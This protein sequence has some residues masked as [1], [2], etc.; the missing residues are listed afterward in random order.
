MQLSIHYY[1]LSLSEQ[2]TKLYE[3]FRDKLIDIQNTNFPLE[4]SIDAAN[5]ASENTQLR[6]LFSQT[7]QHFA[8]Y[9]QQDPL[10]LVVVGEKNNLAIF[11]ALTTHRDAI[12]GTVKGNYTVTSSHDLGK[13]VWPVVKE[14][15]AGATKNAMR[16]LTTAAK[17]K[18]VVSGIGAVGQSAE[19]E[20][21]ST[22][23]VEEDYHVKGSI[24]K[25]DHSLIFSKHV[26]IWEVIDDVVDLIIEKVLKMDGTVI[27]LNSGSLKKLDRIA[28]ILRGGARYKQSH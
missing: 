2:T 3:G 11:E 20:T 17:A 6:K 4:I 19:T 28:L 12:I 10:R 7:D 18:K 21:G 9:Y 22:L 26:D 23:Y 15:I 27:F 25:A 24:R 8:H 14:A 13:I 5:P 1:V 16:E